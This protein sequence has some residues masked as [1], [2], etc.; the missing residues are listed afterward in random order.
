[1]IKRIETQ[2]IINPDNWYG[3]TIDH[4]TIINGDLSNEYSTV[5]YND[6][7]PIFD[8]IDTF[9]D[10]V[11]VNAT[12]YPYNYT[13]DQWTEIVDRLTATHTATLTSNVAS[14]MIIIGSV[15]NDR[16]V[17]SRTYLTN[18]NNSLSAELTI[19]QWTDWL[20]S[21]MHGI[22]YLKSISEK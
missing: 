10:K 9:T 22:R 19:D 1:M 3:K 5:D 14:P 16:I 2:T 4:H 12:S 15:I 6:V 21:L 18:A 7:C 8:Q 20:Q 13:I 11:I 17:V